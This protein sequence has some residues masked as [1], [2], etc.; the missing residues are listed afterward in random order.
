MRTHPSRTRW[1]RASGFLALAATAA[2]QVTPPAAD[3]VVLSPFSVNA[4]VDR[5]YRASNS[6]SASRIDT[7]IKELPIPIQAFTS[8][9]IRDQAP[10]S[11]NDILRFAAGV[12]S[13]RQGLNPNDRAYTLRGLGG[14]RPYRNGFVSFAASFTDAF[15]LER[16][17]VVK[18]P[19]SVLYGQIQPGGL[20]NVL[21]KRPGPKNEIE[22]AQSAGS[23]DLHRSELDVNVV[24][25]SVLSARVSGVVQNNERSFVL[26]K[27]HREG[28][29]PIVQ[30]NFAPH[31][32]LTLELEH[33]ALEIDQPVTP[34]IAGPLP[35]GQI[36]FGKLVDLP[37]DFSFAGIGDYRDDTIDSF[38]ADW[39]TR[40]GRWSGRLAFNRTERQ[41]SEFYTGQANGK[42]V[43]TPGVTNQLTGPGLF[44]WR[45]LR[46]NVIDLSN[47]TIQ[48][49]VTGSFDLRGTKIR[50]LAGYQSDTNKT[51][52]L[53][54]ESS[55]AQV[56]PDWNLLD[57]RTW[58]RSNRFGPG[59]LAN[60]TGN[61][62]TTVENWGSYGVA[63]A[64]L[65]EGR[66]VLL[67]G[68]RYSE[69]EG[70]T[71]NRA[72]R[73]ITSRLY[74]DEVT[75]Q[76]GGIFEL[77]PGVRL[78]ANYSESFVPQSGNRI[79]LD[80][81]VG[82]L[83]P[84]TAEGFDV[85][86]KTDLANGRISSTLTAFKIRNEGAFRNIFLPDPVTG[87][88]RFTSV[89]AGIQESE[90]LEFDA[91]FVPMDSLQAVVT[92]TYMDAVTVENQADPRL[93][94]APAMNA[95][96]NTAGLWLKYSFASAGWKGFSVGAGGNYV[97]RRL[98]NI[99]NLAE[100]LPSYTSADF[101][102]GYETELRG[103]PLRLTL[104]VRNLTDEDY[105]HNFYVRSDPRSVT[106]TAR[107]K[108]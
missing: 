45:R 106:L 89:P 46:E 31:S 95:A 85:G 35:N 6:V 33:Y 108:F 81:P 39:S 105:L 66:L 54:L 99:E 78:F 22:F 28:I 103:K 49:E 60:T 47:E 29:A 77:V 13:E 98:A 57:P 36:G 9:F 3:T 11:L 14:S 7:P 58:N 75:S 104:N 93:V 90:G 53:F 16:V 67:G 24:A 82:P 32:V 69:S 94:G 65:L 79:V 18:G 96:K 1:I 64:T 12:V 21:S 19:S 25:N 40:I 91:T 42:L 30:L 101:M 23:W 37:R 43:V 100:Y 27:E 80:V 97:S 73:V 50:V 5:G 68:G 76:L 15:N 41:T 59:Q 88:N 44:H 51:S 71:F 20:V 84:V 55:N 87:A 83:P 92:Y 8:E 34:T 38:F 17:E 72:T 52:N 26:A 86:L 63:T 48:G 61:T 102:L 10:Q 74:A 2:A 56:L 107:V 70:N 4:G 62:L